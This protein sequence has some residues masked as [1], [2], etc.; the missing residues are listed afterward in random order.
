MEEKKAVPGFDKLVVASSP[1][2][3]AVETVDR[4]MWQV[5]IALM[6]AAVVSVY[7]FGLRALVLMLVGIASAV[8]TEALVEK[9]L[10]KEITIADGSAA[11]TGLLLAF[12]VPANAPWWMVAVGAAFAIAV[13]KQTFGGLGANFVNPALAARAFMLAAWPQHM[14]GKFPVPL[15]SITAA[16]PLAIL[17]GTAT[18]TLPSY[19]DLFI[20]NVGGVLGETSALAL[21]VGGAYLIWQKVI[22]WRTPAGFIGTVAVLTWIF[23]GKGGLFTGDPLHHVLAGGLILGAF[24]M[25]TDYVTSPITPKGRLIFGIGCGFITVLIRLWGGY[26]EGVS[27]SILLMNLVVPFLDRWTLPRVYGVTR[28]RA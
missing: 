24:F 13:V 14:T 2:I 17:K 7:F 22:D 20:G 28:A 8:L 26:P 1:H 3:R 12:N 18:G 23:G 6:P 9:A 21:L 27:Y 4:L 5:I 10:K 16:T 11:L 25:A 19:L 15:D